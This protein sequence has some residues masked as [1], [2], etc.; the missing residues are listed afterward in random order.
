MLSAMLS[1][2]AACAFSCC[3]VVAIAEVY[4]LHVERWILSIMVYAT[5]ACASLCGA[6]VAIA[7]ACMLHVERWI[8]TIMLSMIAA[9]ASLCGAVV[10]IAELCVLH[11]ERWMLS[12]MLSVMPIDLLIG[13]TKPSSKSRWWHLEC[14]N[15][16]GTKLPSNVDEQDAGSTLEE[17]PIAQ[18]QKGTALV[19]VPKQICSAS[20]H[21]A[22]T[23]MLSDVL[24]V[25]ESLPQLLTGLP[26]CSAL[27][28]LYNG[29]LAKVQ[30]SLDLPCTVK[31]ALE[32]ECRRGAHEDCLPKG[33]MNFKS[34]G[35]QLYWLVLSLLWA[36]KTIEG[37]RD[38]LTLGVAASNSYHVTLEQ[39]HG[40]W[41]RKLWGAGCSVMSKTNSAPVNKMFED[42]SIPSVHRL[43]TKL[44]ACYDD[45]GLFDKRLR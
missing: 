20:E 29:Q 3:A 5:A 16:I 39:H 37:I 26:G 24:E 21:A 15:N 22:E 9:C 6:V 10:A 38:G 33:Q 42:L 43:C 11:V 44:E 19:N 1:M 27:I 12:M 30:A 28:S 25:F 8:L 40:F 4:V 18:G 36:L 32:N 31:E 45:I 7:E 17:V 34:V 2:T 13:K 35:C 14:R 41:T 23:L